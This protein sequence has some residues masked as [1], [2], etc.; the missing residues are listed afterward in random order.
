MKKLF[1]LIF[2]FLL[3]VPAGVWVMGLDLGVR[4]DRQW[5]NPPLFV[6][7]A[8]LDNEFYLSFDQYFKDRFSLRGPLVFAK[9]WTDYHLFHTTDSRKVHIGTQGWL[10][11]DQ[12]IEDYRKE[13]CKDA[14]YVEHFFLNLYAVEKIVE[15]SGRKF[16]FSIAP[17][18][19]RIYPQFVG[20]VPGSNTCNR[21]LYD[22]FLDNVTAHPM[23]GFVRL[24]RRLNQG[25]K[26]HTRLYDKTAT[27]WNS[28][29]ASIAARTLLQKIFDDTTAEGATVLE[30]VDTAVTGD[31]VV[32]LLG[33]SM[34]Q[35]ENPVRHLIS[36]D[37]PDSLSAVIYGDA[38][39]SKLAPF[40]VGKFKKLDMIFTDH[41]P[42]KHYGEDL[43][44]YD[45]IL[46]E[47]AESGIK[48]LDINLDKIFSAMETEAPALTGWDLNLTDAVPV[49]QISL[50]VHMDGLEI[51]SM[52]TGSFFKFMSIP[53]SDDK[54][55]RVLKLTMAST[56]PDT[57]AIHLMTDPAYVVY[58]HLKT[59]LT[60]V[61]LPLPFQDSLS[62][63]IN[64]G[65]NTGLFKLQKA[66]I[67]NFSDVP[68]T[69]RPI[70]QETFAEMI[71]SQGTHLFKYRLPVQDLVIPDVDTGLA[72]KDRGKTVQNRKH[73]EIVLKKKAVA[74]PKKP[75][76]HVTDFKEGQ[77]FQR[78]GTK[79]HIIVSGT[80]TGL[81]AAIEARILKAG[82]LEAVVPWT[83][84][85]PHPANGIFM[86]ELDDVP[87]GGWYNL[88][89][90]H[91]NNPTV[92]SHGSHKWGVGMLVACIGQSNMEEWF[93]TGSDLEADPHLRK[94]TEKGWSE[95]GEKGNGAIAFGNRL[96][97]R[98]HI[99]VGLLDYAE[100]GSG[101][102][103]EAD[104]GT[105]YWENTEPGAIYNRFLSG[106]SEVGGS[107][108]YVVWMQGE[109][110]AARGTVTESEYRAS[111]EDFIVK[112]IRADIG[113]GSSRPSLPFLIVMMVKRPGGKD[114]PHQAIRD[115]Q[116]YV[117]ENMADC[118]LAAT[119]L[120]L[121]NKGRQHLS[122]SAYTTLG[123]RVA[124][125][126]L[127][128]LKKE[129]YYRGPSVAAVTRI[130]PE[131]FDVTLHHR[132]GTDFTPNSG[133]TGWEVLSDGISLPVSNVYRY[134]T[135]TIRIVLKN[136][137]SGDVN[138]RYLYGAMPDT[139]NPVFDNSKMVLPLEEYH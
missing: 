14:S 35:S 17:D 64:P 37:R 118:Y 23:K 27:S 62:V 40:M 105:G 65:E 83:V 121:Q 91:S 117:A 66:K 52:G 46:V 11:D 137:V 100:D 104:W 131:T 71:D 97:H 126:V 31:L 133:I 113:N 76:I 93:Y 125:T 4:V 9:N 135:K 69:A 48:T 73:D 68:G 109:A 45:V 43:I 110:D 74:V 87:Q 57:M 25:K 92:S 89:V 56:R 7:E 86:G 30:Q 123:L 63:R 95:M 82:S 99:P 132:G 16:F 79:G 47:S 3:L 15:A 77:I 51:K 72:V 101:L 38:F 138:V 41:I 115:A 19:S 10:Y 134:D 78:K 21:S 2:V 94:H 5:L 34:M 102:R 8:L 60:T 53:G 55:F 20:F 13:A 18:K 81:P 112:Q 50:T 122:P 90:R 120:D 32:K 75:I 84:V 6:R 1:S 129:R 124:Q 108:E 106:I 114:G 107:V 119:T 98:L 85:D 61:Y 116:R 42:S 111:L 70:K 26:N 12:S 49:S 96:I 36:F 67:L 39:M 80:Y 136:G 29:G 54:T 22:L 130:D 127:Y 24:D 128:I 59:G 33:L 58:K 88:Q 44:S 28:L 103:K 139:S